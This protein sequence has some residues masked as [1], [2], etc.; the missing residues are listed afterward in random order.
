[1]M[2]GDVM[3]KTVVPREL[4]VTLTTLDSVSPMG[5]SGMTLEA[6]LAIGLVSTS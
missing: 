4:R 6:I 1:M 5:G 3:L 2:L